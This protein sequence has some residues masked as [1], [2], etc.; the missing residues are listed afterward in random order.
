MNREELYR[1]L[2]ESGISEERAR[3]IADQL[4]QMD[5]TGWT[6]NDVGNFALD[7]INAVSAIPETNV[8]GFQT[9]LANWWETGNQPLAPGQI[10]VNP[11][12]SLPPLTFTPQ[13]QS[14][15]QVSVQGPAVRPGGGPE[16]H[17][18]FR[19]TAEWFMRR[20]MEPEYASQL[21]QH[22]T[23]IDM[24]NMQDFQVERIMY[25][26]LNDARGY[27]GMPRTTPQEIER[28]AAVQEFAPRTMIEPQ[29]GRPFQTPAG[30]SRTELLAESRAR[31]QTLG[32]QQGIQGSNFY[33]QQRAKELEAQWYENVPTRFGA[34][35]TF[36]QS[37]APALKGLG[38]INP[39]QQRFFES[40]LSKAYQQQGMG[41]K[42]QQWWENLTKY[43]GQAFGEGF[44]EQRKELKR[45]KAEPSPWASFLEKF[46]PTLKT[47]Y[48]EL[49]PRQKGVFT[50][51]QRPR[52]RFL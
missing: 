3:A 13:Q 23:T 5:I 33:R 32:E 51:V 10:G 11:P 52:T 39:N 17:V 24:E 36:E 19:A 1:L 41:A 45:L 48:A 16:Q 27:V 7:T 44:Q 9:W 29:T 42:Q 50:R 15:T 43:P 31:Q 18:D 21:A 37:S 25:D 20:G 47:R 12:V 28:E 8:N 2:I 14:Q 26:T 46:A 38:A 49:T 40:E 35:P 22:L 34:F 6:E 4:S 30:R